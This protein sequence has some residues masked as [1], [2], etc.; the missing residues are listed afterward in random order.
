LFDSFLG[1]E[2]ESAATDLPDGLCDVGV[3]KITFSEGLRDWGRRAMILT[4]YA[5][6]FA[7]LLRK[8]RENL[9]QGNRG[10]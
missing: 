2:P 4:N 3:G 7:L 10:I 6:A 1:V 9:S 8:S 5:L